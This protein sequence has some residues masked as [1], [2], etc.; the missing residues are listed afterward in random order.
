M[1][2]K[3]ATAEAPVPTNLSL[4]ARERRAL[5]YMANA[6]GVPLTVYV[7]RLI[8]SDLECRHLTIAD[9]RFDP[10]KEKSK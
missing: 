6:A 7:A 9:K 4:P 10:P 1:P 3:R 8:V 2:R 5:E